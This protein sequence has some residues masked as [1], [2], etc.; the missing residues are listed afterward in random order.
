M[1]GEGVV[2]S[3]P[4]IMLSIAL[5]GKISVQPSLPTDLSDIIFS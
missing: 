2:R 4:I 5:L 1:D 3:F